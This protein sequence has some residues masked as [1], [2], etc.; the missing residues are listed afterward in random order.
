M[1]LCSENMSNA[2][3]PFRR[4]TTLFSSYTHDP[5]VD[6]S[7]KSPVKEQ[8]VAQHKLHVRLLCDTLRQLGVDAILDQYYEA[9]PPSSWPQWAQ[10]MLINSD[11]TLMICTRSYFH[12]VT[13]LTSDGEG[14]IDNVSGQGKVIF[15]LLQ[16]PNYGTRFI[17][18]LF[19]KPD[20]TYIPVALR[21]GSHYI[22][23]NF[24][25]ALERD[26]DFR[27]LYARLTGQNETSLVP[28]GP[29]LP[30]RRECQGMHP[31][32]NWICS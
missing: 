4:P 9:D 31:A 23:E 26:R 22:I 7:R 21:G 10:N 28:L 24:P 17:P 19:S 13:S 25:P 3:S 15:S 20:A 11:Y 5:S 2:G 27:S 18:V 29:L 1:F 30:L 16:E 8:D 32:A 14:T 6:S 12:R